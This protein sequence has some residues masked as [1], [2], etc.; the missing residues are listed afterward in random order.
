MSAK[1]TRCR[2]KKGQNKKHEN[3]WA[4]QDN[5][6]PLTESGKLTKDD[7]LAL[8]CRDKYCIRS[9]MFVN[10][11]EWDDKLY[12]IFGDLVGQTAD[13]MRC[14]LH[15]YVLTHKHRISVFA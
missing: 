8:N 4:Y 5:L 15:V 13:F 7:V 9:V 1:S 3:P 6:H 14:W 2:T 12:R 10:P 11:G